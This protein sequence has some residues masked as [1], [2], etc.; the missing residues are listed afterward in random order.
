MPKSLTVSRAATNATVVGR[1]GHCALPA[2]GCTQPFDANRTT[3][4]ENS[5]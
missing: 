5:V 3:E 2:A 4:I 1:P